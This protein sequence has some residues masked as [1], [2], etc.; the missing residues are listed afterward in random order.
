RC[1]EVGM[2]KGTTRRE[3]KY[4]RKAVSVCKITSTSSAAANN[5]NANNQDYGLSVSTN[6]TRSTTGTISG[7]QPIHNSNALTSSQSQISKVQHI[8]S[9]LLVS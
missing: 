7:S 1:Y 9:S 2:T 6:N 4:R 8:I 5:G 3:G